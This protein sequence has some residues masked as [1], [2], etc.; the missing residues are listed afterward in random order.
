MHTTIQLATYNYV[1][2]CLLYR[3][4][5]SLHDCTQLQN[6]FDY[7]SLWDYNWQMQTIVPL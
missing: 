6:D 1:D 3:T 2:D 4:I 7:L 5:H